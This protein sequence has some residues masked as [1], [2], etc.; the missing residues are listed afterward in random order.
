MKVIAIIQGN[1]FTNKGE[2]VQN[3]KNTLENV[4][5]DTAIPQQWADNVSKRIG[6][7]ENISAHFVWCYPSRDS[8]EFNY[9]LVGWPFPITPRGMEILARLSY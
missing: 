7:T 6:T 4:S 1:E 9:S 3:L 8:K 2:I 5:F